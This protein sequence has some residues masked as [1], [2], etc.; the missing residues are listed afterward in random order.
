MARGSRPRRLAVAIDP[1]P[2]LRTARRDAR[3]RNRNTTGW[4]RSP[5]RLGVSVAP[6]S[7]ALR[8]ERVGAAPAIE[9][10]IREA[11]CVARPARVNGNML[12]PAQLVA[13]ALVPTGLGNHRDG[14]GENPPTQRLRDLAVV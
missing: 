4:L 6:S 5:R 2:V 13:D 10:E 12:Q 8:C 14:G 7:R 11:G 9:M 3:D 1:R